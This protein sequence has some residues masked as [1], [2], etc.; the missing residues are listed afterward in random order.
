M[1]LWLSALVIALPL[2][3]SDPAYGQ[4]Q[5]IPKHGGSIGTSSNAKSAK[6]ESAAAKSLPAVTAP[7]AKAPA[8]KPPAASPLSITPL[9]DN[10]SPIGC[11][12]FFYRPTNKKEQGPLLL[13]MNGDGSASVKPDGQLATLKLVDEQHSRR[14]DNTISAQDRMLLKLRGEK[15]NASVSGLAE[16]NCVKNSTGLACASVSYQAVLSVDHMGR[17]ASMPAWGFCGCR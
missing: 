15:T 7:V 13:K 12:C 10:E 16:R 11:G 6:P 5:T 9:T 17:K 8:A 4:E 2:A 14:L 3:L 1:T